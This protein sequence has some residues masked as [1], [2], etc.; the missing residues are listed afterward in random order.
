MFRFCEKF[1]PKMAIL[2]QNSA[3]FAEQKSQHWRKKSCLGL[4]AL[5]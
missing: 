1:S 5:S 3:I 4:K 2:T